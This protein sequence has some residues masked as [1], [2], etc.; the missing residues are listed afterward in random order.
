MPVFWVLPLHDPAYR[1]VR[2]RNGL[3]AANERFVRAVLNEFPGVTVLDPSPVVPEAGDYADPCHLARRGA[4]ALSG[5]VAE[6]VEAS[7]TRRGRGGAR[8]R[9]VAPGPPRGSTG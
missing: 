9:W 4:V 3:D 1:A 2:G 5:A 6:A 7:L 8:S